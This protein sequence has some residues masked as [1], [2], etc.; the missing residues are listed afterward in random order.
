M[1]FFSYI[2]IQ[3]NIKM[4]DT[5]NEICFDLKTCIQKNVLEKE[6]ENTVCN[7]LV[8]LGW[9]KYRGEIETQYPVQ[10]G[11][12]NK[13]ADIVVLRD[14]IEQFVVEVK[15]PNHILCEE[16]ERQLFSYMRLLKRQVSFGLYIGDKI[17]L[18]YDDSASQQLPEQVFS[19]DFEENNPEGFRF[20]ELF[21]KDSFNIQ[22]LTDFCKEQKKIF[23][24]RKL[25]QDEIKRILS[26]KEG[27]LFKDALKEKFLREGHTEDWADS[28]LNQIMLTV[29]PNV[30]DSPRDEVLHHLPTYK[31]D[32]SGKKRKKDY[33]QYSILGGESLAKN[34]F[35]LSV[36]SRYVS[37]HPD[38]YRAYEK[39]FNVLKSDSQGVIKEVSTLRSNQFRNYF[40]N[41]RDRL[42]S[43]DG[44]EFVVC[45]QW[46][47]K[48]IQP[49]IQFANSVGYDVTEHK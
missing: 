15:R 42:R 5:W 35:V 47:I 34:R 14:G 12:E 37:E 23:R 3:K 10:A 22:T 24:D 25:M 26:D 33:T 45:N 16:D 13:Y 18:Y 11:H 44:V 8:L 21:S 31:Y 17:C 2:C 38:T 32:E 20:V 30:K 7:C 39:I 41:E 9:K 1:L 4:N 29:N 6:Y 36:V 19:V 27:L 40:M 49:I 28:I 46:D 48:L 43:K